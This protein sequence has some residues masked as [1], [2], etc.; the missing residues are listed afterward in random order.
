MPHSNARHSAVFVKTL[1]LDLLAQGFSEA[2][3][4]E[5]ST[6]KPELMRQDN[7]EAPFSDIAAFFEH[8]SEL[9]GDDLLGFRRGESREMRKIGLVC[10]VGL[11]APTV[12]D[13]LHNI[14][15]Y[16]RVFSDA[17]EIDVS[18]LAQGGRLRWHFSVSNTVNR[19]QY[20][21][22]GASG[23][24]SS[25]RQATNRPVAPR[26]MTFRHLRN[27]NIAELEGFLG[28]P[29][30]FGAPENM[31]T[32]AAAD[33]H[34]PL[35]TADDDLYK[36]LTD[37]AEKILH[38]KTRAGSDLI[39]EVER[40]IADRLAIGAA[41]QDTVSRALGMSP[42]TLARRLAGEQTTFFQTLEGLRK[43]LAVSYLKNSDLTLGDIAFLLGYSSLS[44][45]S[46]AFKRWLGR[47]PGQY[48]TG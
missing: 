44:S 39:V 13:C 46:G 27:T 37:Y 2:Q 24:L 38:S 20:V 7:P 1:A 41:N 6:L 8:A 3:I 15:R 9:T 40:A 48:R 5:R 30:Q 31:F 22:F 42:R 47:T 26:Q 45:F 32:F 43:S 10:Y 33:L 11:T 12:L 16:R 17:I 25:L 14:A 18:E 4:F 21:E 36:V 19:R 29:V 35:A 34:L 28:C 23:I